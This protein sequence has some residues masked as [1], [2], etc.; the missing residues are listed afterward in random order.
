MINNISERIAHK[1]VQKKIISEED[2]ELYHYGWFVVLTDLWLFASTLILGI[3]FNITLPSVFFFV[4]FF[5]IRRFAGGYHA[6]TELQCQIMSLSFLF[7]SILAMKF[8]LFNIDDIYL[9]ILNL[10]CVILLPIFSPADTPQKPLSLN[11]RKKFKKII[12]IIS[13]ILLIADFILIY[14]GIDFIAVPVICA[15]ILET[16]LVILG[17]LLNHRLAED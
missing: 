2:Y 9:I 5:V 12:S 7:L 17:R 8:L 14:Y 10:I 15:F 3:I 16:V 6:K 4:T 11:E 13:I 1:W